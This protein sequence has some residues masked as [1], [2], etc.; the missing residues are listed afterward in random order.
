MRNTAGVQMEDSASA[1]LL[2][3]GRVP[4]LVRSARVLICGVYKPKLALL[5]L[6][7]PRSTAESMILPS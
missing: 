1:P 6:Y 7:S 2:H 3:A 5:C 4:Q